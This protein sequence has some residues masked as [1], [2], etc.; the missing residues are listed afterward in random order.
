M[1]GVNMTRQTKVVFLRGQRR[2]LERKNRRGFTL[3]EL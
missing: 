3:I 1:K 2:A